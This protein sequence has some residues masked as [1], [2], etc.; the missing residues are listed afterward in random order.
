MAVVHVMT[1]KS[2]GLPVLVLMFWPVLGR[3]YGRPAALRAAHFQPAPPVRCP[4]F[5]ASSL[6]SQGMHVSIFGWKLALDFIYHRSD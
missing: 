1:L 6:H 2:L 5:P 4:I 3:G